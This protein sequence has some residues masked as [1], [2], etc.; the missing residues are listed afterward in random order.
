MAGQ[1]NCQDEAA[2]CEHTAAVE[3][4][5][6]GLFAKPTRG[7]AARRLRGGKI[8]SVWKDPAGHWLATR[9]RN[10]QRRRPAAREVDKAP[11][12][13]RAGLLRC[14]PCRPCSRRPRRLDKRH[15]RNRCREAL[16]RHPRRSR[17]EIQNRATAPRGNGSP[18]ATK[19]RTS[20]RTGIFSGAAQRRL[21][22]RT[23][24]CSI[25]IY[26]FT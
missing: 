23:E 12:P 10:E 25:M 4:T 7:R 6:K 22:A 5:R 26:A 17:R 24:K 3:V 21:M 8:A 2:V 13:A 18:P 16:R 20:E 1:I 9:A 11:N 19:Q 15:R 14:E